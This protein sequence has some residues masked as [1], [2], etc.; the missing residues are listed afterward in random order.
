MN[1]SSCG[2]L[3]TST[4]I[5]ILYEMNRQLE[6]YILVPLIIMEAIAAAPV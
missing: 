3:T 4:A 1:Y 5:F 6:A 2:A